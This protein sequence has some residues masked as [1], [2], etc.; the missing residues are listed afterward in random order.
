MSSRSTV[1]MQSALL[2]SAANFTAQCARIWTTLGL[3][4]QA[5]DWQFVQSLEEAFTTKPQLSASSDKAPRTAWHNVFFKLALDQTVGLFIMDFIF[6]VCTNAIRLS[7]RRLISLE[8]NGKIW[9]IIRNAWKIWPACS[10]V[11]FL[12]VPVESRV[13][14]ASLVGFGWNIF[15]ALFTLA[16]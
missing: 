5:L 1:V 10:L 16:K 4:F 6:L 8:V 7:D 3:S 12:W 2:K 13:L 15:L 14:V 9:S 11:N